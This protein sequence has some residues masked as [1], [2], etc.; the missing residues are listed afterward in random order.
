ML[1]SFFCFL[2]FLLSVHL[3]GEIAPKPS[4]IPL[5][6]GFDFPVAPPNADDYYKSRGFR[7][8]GHLGEDWLNTGGSS[9]SLGKPVYS[10]GPG[11]VILARDVHV[12]WGNVI[13]IRHAYFENGKTE[14]IDSLYAHLDHID[15][16]EGDVVTKG[17]HIGAI[18]N[19]HGMYPAHLHFEIH[20]NLN[21]G[22]NHTGFAKTLL[23]YW[24]PTDFIVKRRICSK[25]PSK[26]LLPSTHFDIPAPWSHAVKSHRSK[27]KLE[28]NRL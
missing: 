14:F 25:G 4:S 27:K 28:K 8:G 18:G 11:I 7:A 12:A 24:V 15:V 21:I 22:V 13:I 16:K 26:A 2:F 10:I 23:N 6:E 1:R 19:N 3:F 5:A 17:Q 9:C 20:K